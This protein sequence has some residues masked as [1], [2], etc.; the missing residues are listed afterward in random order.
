MKT[1]YYFL[2]IFSIFLLNSCLKSDVNFEETTTV[3]PLV[4]DCGLYAFWADTLWCAEETFIKVFS[5]GGKN[6]LR[7]SGWQYRELGVF[8]NPCRE[9]FQVFLEDFQGIGTYDLSYSEDSDDNPLFYVALHYDIQTSVFK[10][11]EEFSGQVIITKYDEITK[12][13]A[14]EFRGDLQG[15]WPY[16]LNEEIRPVRGGRFRGVFE[17]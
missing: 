4:E 8:P 5:D 3:D 9:T 17:D 16:P 12:I 1:V 2:L 6:K 15:D 11:M 13:I 7:V 14:G 10:F